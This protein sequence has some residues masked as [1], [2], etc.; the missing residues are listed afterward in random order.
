MTAEIKAKKTFRNPKKFP[1]FD[2]KNGPEL[3]P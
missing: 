1:F 3:Y 2:L